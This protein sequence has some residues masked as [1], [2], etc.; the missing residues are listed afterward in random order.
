MFVNDPTLTQGDKSALFTVRSSEKDPALVQKIV[1]YKLGPDWG[2]VVGDKDD[3]GDL[4]KRHRDEARGD[5]RSERPGENGHAGVR[6]ID[7]RLRPGSRQGRA[8]QGARVL[9]KDLGVSGL[10]LDEGPSEKAITP[11]VVGLP[12]GAKIKPDD[13]RRA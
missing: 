9:E 10:K 3:P 13:L 12:A 8:G 2:K 1:N 6:Q 4:L 5:R 7:G 11:C